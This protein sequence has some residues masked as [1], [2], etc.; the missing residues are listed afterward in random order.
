MSCASILAGKN[1]GVAPDAKLYYFAVPD[2]GKNFENYSTAID[3]II[4]LNQGLSKKDK[5]RIVSISDGLLNDDERWEE[6]NKTL[7]KA[8]VEGIIVVYSNN[9]GSK[10]VW[11]GCPPYKDRNNVLNY[12]IAIAYMNQKIND[13]SV[14]IIPG[15]Y[16]T[17]ANNQ[18]DDGYT[19][20]GAGGWSW[21]IPYFVGLCT[22][23]LEINP[24]LTYEQ[25]QQTLE[26]TKSETENGFYV[27]NPVN[28]IK[29]LE[30]AGS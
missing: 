11:G 27:I 28:Y 21:A 16:R 9:V 2:N 24:Q 23:G 25:M 26:E 29:K 15:D 12:D 6:W 3:K 19:Y 13:K 8:N 1:C 7:R 17:T 10:F 4:E 18:Y 20:Y 30:R 22:L 14:I 5:I